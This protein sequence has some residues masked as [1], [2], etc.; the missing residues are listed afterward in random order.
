MPS[1]TI[2][3]VGATG[4]TGSSAVKHLSRLLLSSS[5]SKQPQRIIALTRNANSAASKELGQL[6]QVEVQEKDW[7]TIDSEWLIEA[8]VSRVYLAPHNFPNQFVDE[9]K[10]LVACKDAGVEYLV[11]LST[12]IHYVTPDN[13]VYYGRTHWA[14]ENLLEQSAFKKLNWTALRANFFANTILLPSIDWLQKNKTDSPMPLLV[15]EEAPVAIIDA[16]D[17]GEAAAK[18]LALDD[19]SPHYSKKYNL[20]GPEDL[21]GKDIVALLEQVTHRKIQADYRNVTLFKALCEHGGYPKHVWDSLEYGRRGNLWTGI[22]QLAS[23]PTSPELLKLAPPHSTI[24][25]FIQK[26]FNQ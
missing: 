3:V 5:P 15:D 21:T 7:T 22:S 23:T 13:P 18:L 2:L 12:N 9:S 14:I 20:S 19:P 11:K 8:K 25:E 26:N 4:N 17:V 24:K 16:Q 10:F 1:L 6:D